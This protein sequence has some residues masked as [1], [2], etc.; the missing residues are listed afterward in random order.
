M[1]VQNL[2]SNVDFAFGEKLLSTDANLIKQNAD[3]IKVGTNITADANTL[4][5]LAN[6]TTYRT[7]APFGAAGVRVIAVPSAPQANSRCYLKFTHGATGN[8]TEVR[9]DNG[10]FT[11]T[12]LATVNSAGG[13]ESAWEGYW[14]GSTWRTLSARS[15]S[16]T[17]TIAQ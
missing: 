7:A 12:L 2:N 13:T 16:G 8:N 9:V 10:A 3:D 4:I 1:A 15:G 5:N 11:G 6:G 17:I 14:D